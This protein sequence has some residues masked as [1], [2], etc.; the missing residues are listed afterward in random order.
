VINLSTLNVRPGD[1]LTAE[2]INALAHGQRAAGIRASGG[3]NVRQ[4]ASGQI[5][6]SGTFTGCFVA[7]VGTAG[8]GARSGSTLGNGNVEIQVKGPSTGAY[9]DSGLSVTVDSIS[10]TTGGVP[11]GTWVVCSYQDD[12]TPTLTSVDCGNSS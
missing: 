1:V 6:I 5:Q 4:T 8:I 12:G 3:I 9:V 7:I 10:S 2:L 11:S